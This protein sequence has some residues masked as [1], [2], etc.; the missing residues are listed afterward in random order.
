MNSKPVLSKQW[1]KEAVVY[2]I[3]PRSFQDSNGDGVGDLQGIIQR[4]DYIKSLGVDVIWLNPVYKSPNEDGGY[5]VSDYYEIMNEF[6]S[7]GYFDELLKGIHQRGMRLIMDVVL[8][9]TSAEHPWF[10][11]SRKSKDNEYRDFYFWKSGENGK[12]PNNWMSYFGGS[13]WEYDEISQ[14]YYLHIYARKQPDVNWDNPKLRQNFYRMMRWWLDKG[15]DGFRVDAINSISKKPGL[16]SVTEEDK[17]NLDT[18]YS[19]GPNLH[20]YLKEMRSETFGKHKAMSVGETPGA[21]PEEA[22]K[23]AAPESNEF[24]MIFYFDLLKIDFGPKGRFDPK[25]WTVRGFKHI[26]GLWQKALYGKAWH[27]TAFGNHDFARMVSRFGNDTKYRRESAKM[28]ATMLLTHYGTPYIFQGDEIGMTNVNLTSMDQVQDI[29]SVNN[30]NILREQGVKE[31]DF[32][33]LV[34]KQGRDH[35]RTPMQ[36]SAQKNAGFTTGSPWMIVN[37]NYSTINVDREEKELNSVLHFYRMLI[38][39]RKENPVLIYGDY[40]QLGETHETLYIYKRS[41]KHT[42]ALV[43]LNWSSSNSTLP[44]LPDVN[45]KDYSVLMDSY[46]KGTQSFTNQALK[47]YQALVLTKSVGT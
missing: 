24:D 28:L 5:D 30:W 25:T 42:E 37:S 8:N 27:A 18:I 7:M 23:Y 46:N 39:L 35:A 45:A 41:Y 31:A 13:A 22:L 29:D 10:V 20:T 38:K 1:W 11:A 12:E 44:V 4:L 14:E 16:P 26:L 6:G 3:Y 19:D 34:N 47:P 2:Q 32:L 9:H 43:I 40:S 15:V 21:T 36:W 33:Q 17:Y